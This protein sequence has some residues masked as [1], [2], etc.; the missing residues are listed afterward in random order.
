MA[1]AER[2]FDRPSSQVCLSPPNTINTSQG[3]NVGKL[4]VR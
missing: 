3:A 1:S 2:L 4:I